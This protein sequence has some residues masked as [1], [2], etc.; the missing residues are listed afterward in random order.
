[1]RIALLVLALFIN[2]ACYQLSAQ[3][4]CDDAFFRGVVVDAVTGDSIRFVRIDSY[5]MDQLW[6]GASDFDGAFAIR[7]PKQRMFVE[8]KA[9]GY[10]TER[11]VV[12]L[13]SG[14]L[15]LRV[16]LRPTDP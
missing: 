2:G 8:V 10:R 4:A 6:T 12:D 14:W 9:T 7:L 1:M 11:F 3:R 15:D 13:R 16:A 5:R